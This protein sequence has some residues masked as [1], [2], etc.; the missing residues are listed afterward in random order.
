MITRR[1]SLQLA[2]GAVAALSCPAAMAESALIT[3]AVPSSGERLPVVGLGSSASFRAL[4]GGDDVAALGAVLK[5]L[6]EHGGKVF[7][8]A[9]S[10]GDSEAVAGRLA[11]ELGLTEKLFWATKLNVAGRDGSGADPEL[12]QAQI[13][14]SFARVDRTTI[15]LV[16]V[17]NVADIPVQLGLLKELR[18]AGRIRHLG[19]TNTRS[20]LYDELEKLMRRER[21]DFIGI[22]YAID[23]RKMAE[24]ILPLA[25]DRG[26]AVLVYAPFGR[27]RLWDRVRGKALPDW[28]S[29]FG[30]NSWAQFFLKFVIAHPAVTVATPATSKAHHMMDNLG[31]ARGELPD[32]AMQK[33]MIEYLAD[34]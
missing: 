9:P 19:I 25:I 21:L 13:E 32:A 20:Q 29:E 1:Q 5:A 6:V 4:A 7:D 27:T 33:R 23:N 28:A 3:R 14:D 24:R 18:Q 17:H 22:D 26:I 12:A 15:D 31:A 10:Y 2:A 11:A 8:T 16:Q 34:L 30:A